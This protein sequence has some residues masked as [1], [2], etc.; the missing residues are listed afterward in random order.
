MLV[1]NADMSIIYL[2]SIFKNMAI[3]NS[4]LTIPRSRS[5][6]LD[7]FKYILEKANNGLPTVI[8]RSDT[9]HGDI[10]SN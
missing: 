3:A 10:I 1:L 2:N 5:I 6:L 4:T 9:R 8:L 7:N